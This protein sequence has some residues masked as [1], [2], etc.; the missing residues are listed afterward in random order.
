MLMSAVVK[1]MVDEAAC[2]VSAGL[3]KIIKHHL[4]K[5]LFLQVCKQWLWRLI[6]QRGDKV[7]EPFVFFFL[8]HVEIPCVV[9]PESHCPG[10][11]LVGGVCRLTS[12]LAQLL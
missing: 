6:P 10:L 7:G 5:R 2:L 12:S 11:Q 9:H 3:H 8:I 4:M 1:N